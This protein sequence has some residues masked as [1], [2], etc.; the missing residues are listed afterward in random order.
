MIRRECGEEE[1]EDSPAVQR[2]LAAKPEMRFGYMG[3]AIEQLAH[4]HVP[5]WEFAPK[6]HAIVTF[7]VEV[8]HSV[9]IQ[10]ESY[11]SLEGF[12]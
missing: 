1:V 9:I 6:D 12:C 4:T 7:D 11:G 2:F 3:T 10:G 8:S 5:E